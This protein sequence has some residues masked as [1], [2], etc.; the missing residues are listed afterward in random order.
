MFKSF[1]KNKIP[2]PN[3]KPLLGLYVLTLS[4]VNL[5]CARPTEEVN[6][7][8][9]VKGQ[10]SGKVACT[11]NNIVCRPISVLSPL[12]I[13]DNSRYR[14]EAMMLVFVA[15]CLV[16]VSWV[17]IGSPVLNASSLLPYTY[18][19]QPSTKLFCKCKTPGLVDLL[20]RQSIRIGNASFTECTASIT[21]T[22]NARD[23][24]KRVIGRKL[25]SMA[26]K[27]RRAYSLSR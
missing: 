4:V 25:E 10:E 27:E 2:L 11:V 8:L 16:R 6:A 20:M 3:I 23:G 5:A 18:S 17:L 19:Y 24:V 15:G 9:K 26:R 21:I 13:S 12:R 7:P 22:S 1:H 14:A